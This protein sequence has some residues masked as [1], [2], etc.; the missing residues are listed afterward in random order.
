MLI[1]LKSHVFLF[2]N[3]VIKEK[4]LEEVLGFYMLFFY[5]FGCDFVKRKSSTNHKDKVTGCK[6][7]IGAA[8]F[9]TI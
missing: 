1:T 6:L 7:T 2:F 8:S 5:T 3:I 4:S 9:L